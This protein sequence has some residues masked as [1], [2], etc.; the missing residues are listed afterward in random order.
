MHNPFEVITTE[1]SDIKKMLQE[2]SQKATSQQ[3]EDLPDLIK[4]DEAVKETGYKKGYIYEL[5]YRRAIPFHKVGKSLRFSRK[6]LR[7][8][9]LAGRPHMMQQAVEQLAVN[10]V[11]NK[12]GK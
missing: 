9:I 7:Q 2:L 10:H 4:A 11:V 3:T 6:E 12:Q 1:L 5:V 8:W